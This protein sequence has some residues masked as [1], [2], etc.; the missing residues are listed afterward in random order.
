MN[1][2]DQQHTNSSSK[3]E[4]KNKDKENS[5]AVNPNPKANANIRDKLSEDPELKQTNTDEVG[6]EITDGEDG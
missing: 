1:T 2:D 5:I 6:S 3:D 4:P